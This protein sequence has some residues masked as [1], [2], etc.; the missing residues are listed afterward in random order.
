LLSKLKVEERKNVELWAEAT[1]LISLPDT[2]QNVEF[3]STIIETNNTVPVILTDE[4]DSIISARNFDYHKT[5]DFKY[6]RMQLEKIRQKIN[7]YRLTLKMVT[8]TLFTI[9]TVLSSLC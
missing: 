9:K 8:L 3:L 6:F 1:R 7:R 5:G 2:S 4:S